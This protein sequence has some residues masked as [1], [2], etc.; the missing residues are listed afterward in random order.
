MLRPPLVRQ[1]GPLTVRGGGPGSDDAA[2]VEGELEQVEDLSRTGPSVLI[3]CPVET[4][5]EL[6]GHVEEY[7]LEPGFPGAPGFAR[8]CLGDCCCHSGP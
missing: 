7:R 8:R 6:L 4:G 1:G 3:F 2:A 5:D